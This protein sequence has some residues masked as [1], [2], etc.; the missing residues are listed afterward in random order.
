MGVMTVTKKLPAQ[1]EPR[2]ATIRPLVAAR[3][4]TAPTYAAAFAQAAGRKLLAACVVV[5]PLGALA[6][7][8]SACGAA[9]P[10]QPAPYYKGE[11][12]VAEPPPAASASGSASAVPGVQ[13]I[14]PPT[15]SAQ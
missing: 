8:V 1:L 5:F 9:Q 3:P 13:P 15:P 14:A 11:P 4:A 12:R 2:A 10:T 7:T 6:G